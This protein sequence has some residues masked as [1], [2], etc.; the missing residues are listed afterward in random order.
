MSDLDYTM[1]PSPQAPLPRP[2]CGL[3]ASSDSVALISAT[4]QGPR[5]AVVG[6][7]RGADLEEMP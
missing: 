1:P 7:L 4:L 6:I 2:V 5:Q 3:W